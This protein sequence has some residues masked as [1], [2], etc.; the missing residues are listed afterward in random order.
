MSILKVVHLPDQVSKKQ[1]ITK[2]L[3]IAVDQKQREEQRVQAVHFVSLDPT[4]YRAELKKLIGPREP[5]SI[6]VAAIRTLRGI[7][8]E[9][10]AEYLLQQWFELSPRVQ[11]EAMN[12]FLTDTARIAL[13]LTA[14]EKGKVQP[15]AVGWT[16]SVRLMNHSNI[17]LRTRARKL[18]SQ[19]EEE[20]LAVNKLYQQAL[21]L[22]GNPIRG[23]QVY[24]KN[25]GTC[26]QV[27]GG[28]GNNFG[29][30]LGSIHNWSRDAIMVNIIA[31]NLSISSG[32][33]TWEVQ[34]KN[35]DAFQGIISTETPAAIT[36]KNASLE[37]KTINRSEIESLKVIN[38]SAMP[39]GLEK[40]INQQEKADLLYFLKTVE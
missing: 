6:Q 14:I 25:C 35:G 4:P 24:M 10:L 1:A 16:R 26:H 23:K 12:T 32:Y 8:G 39:V 33:E 38:I 11:D 37:Q 20:R 2:A 30:D 15:G 36:I 22:D 31:P 27:R 40:Q 17:P 34:T 28:L 13:L 29:P 3:S 7:K 5:S 21:S 9:D 19:T 18:L